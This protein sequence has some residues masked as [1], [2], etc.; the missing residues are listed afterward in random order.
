MADVYKGLTIQFGADESQLSTALRKITGEARSASTALQLVKKG[1]VA[2][3]G[4]TKLA[5]AGMAEYQKQIKATEERLKTLKLAE[6]QIGKDNMSSEQWARLQADITLTEDKVKNL[7][8]EMREFDIAQRASNTGIGKAAATLKEAAPKL[9]SI[10]S[11][12]TKTVTPAIIGI[13]TASVA[14]AVKMDSSLTSVRKT[15]DGTEEQYQALKDAA[16]EFSKTNAVDPATVMD[17]QAL[18][19]QLG[20]TIDELDKFSQVA[21][22]LDIA[23]D[24][25]LEEGASQMAQFANIT[26]MARGDIDRYASAIVNLGN[27][28][29]V[30]ESAVSNMAQRTAAAGSQVGMSQAQIL[31]WS[32]AM[33]QMG[34]S[35]EAG[36]TAFSTTI[37]NIDK[38]VA[39]G[40]GKLEE[41]ARVSGKTSEQFSKDWKENASDAFMDLL[42]GLEQSDNMSVELEKMGITAVRQT[43]VMKRLA[44]ATE[45]TGEAIQIATDGWERNTALSEE[46]ANR[47]ASLAAKFQILKN[48]VM[49]VADQIGG[50]LADALLDVIDSMAPLFD[51]I[52]QGAQAFADM[53]QEQQRAIIGLA[54]FVAALGPMLKHAGN[55]A[56]ALDSL[57]KLS[58][59]LGDIMGGAGKAAE[60][61]ADGLAKVSSVGLKASTALKATAAA[62]LLLV[63]ALVAKAIADYVKHMEDV[64]T[65]SMG[66]ATA[67]QDAAASAANVRATFEASADG[68]RAAVKGYQELAREADS[69]TQAN[70]DLAG[71]LQDTWS[72]FYTNQELLSQYVG[73]IDALSGKSELTADEQARL[74]AAV[75]GY[76]EITGESL[77]VTDATTGELSESTEEILKNADA[78]IENAKAQALQ[79]AMVDVQKNIIDTNNA[80]K[81]HEATLATM[82]EAYDKYMEAGDYDAANGMRYQ[83][84][85]EKETIKELN[86]ELNGLKGTEA[87]YVAQMG[88]DAATIQSV[89]GA[90]RNLMSAL[91]DSGGSIEGVAASFEA[92]GISAEDFAAIAEESPD[93]LAAMVSGLGKLDEAGVPIDKLKDKMG[94][95][96]ISMD[97]LSDLSMQDWNDIVKHYKRGSGD[98]TGVMDALKG[99]VASKSKEIGN[100][101]VSGLNK[102]QEFK[103]KAEKSVTTYA[104]SLVGKKGAV[105]SASSKVGAATSAMD[106]SGAALQWG[107]D[108][109]M[110]YARG[111]GTQRAI[112]TA[113]SAASNLAN[114]VKNIIGHSVP[115]EGPLHNHGQGE[116]GWGI[117]TATNFADGIRKGVPDVERQTKLLAASVRNNLTGIDAGN[118]AANMTAKVGVDVGRA[119]VARLDRM[120]DALAS[121]TTT[122]NNQMNVNLNYDAGSDVNQMARDLARSVK[123]YQL[124]KGA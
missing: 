41:F 55:A 73:A 49:A 36:G 98:V 121:S 54:G 85:Q 109:A 95:L 38:A 76:N 59:Q 103:K 44:G 65:A 53:D 71:R 93:K 40:G 66:I 5:Q 34:I 84:E 77:E 8:K 58:I 17:V 110:N 107:I 4:N 94:E 14:T 72:E 60:A 82:Q 64:R 30:T 56:N 75:A 118:I 32:G 24:M 50:P 25:Q 74:A 26:G 6:S 102:E 111:V 28:T 89:I 35:A 120:N 15:V 2:D 33:A 80:I 119:A 31:G 123:R 70:A 63:A 108:T 87:D 79:T 81:D 12:M 42:K 19:A 29:A 114:A 10:G 117:E 37:S 47:N 57:S 3:P 100:A 22:G 16:I 51:L 9:E 90:N 1:L 52:G 43:D 21:T 105:S 62:A 91:N 48:R 68:A 116:I 11:T 88:E 18:G 69:V 104:N 113:R 106:K 23:T 92:L 122:T 97:D 20:F 13:A 124:A 67:Q 7:K 78:W 27:N 61:S 115:K 46:V 39:T 101:S 83:M 96:G 45:E 86:S 112:N 99:K